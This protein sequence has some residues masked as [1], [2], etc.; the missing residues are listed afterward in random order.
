MPRTSKVY[1]FP[2]L[3][4]SRPSDNPTERYRGM[5]LDSS[6]LVL[7]ITVLGCSIPYPACAHRVCFDQWTRVRSAFGVS[8]YRSCEWRYVEAN[9]AMSQV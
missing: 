6:G 9:V 3:C 1:V 4:G 2:M 7:L 5:E 8:R